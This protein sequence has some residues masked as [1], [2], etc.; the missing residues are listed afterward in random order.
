MSLRICAALG[1][2]LFLIQLGCD[3]LVPAPPLSKAARQLALG[4]QI[5]AMG[6]REAIGKIEAPVSRQSPHF[7]TLTH[8]DST[9]II[10]K[11]EESTGAD[12]L[13]TPRL[14]ARLERLSW[15][16]RAEWSGVRLR[17]TEAWDEDREHG[18]QS[19]H[20][21]GRAVDLTTSDLDPKKL[22]RLAFLAA[23]A[24]FDWVYFESRTHVHASV[25]K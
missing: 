2:G 17:V 4:D 18:P 5:P 13:M 9:E 1:L 11:D 22:G 23:E 12:R 19:A 25:R 16:V 6:E 10:F 7:R 24:G 3:G 15:L 8:N 14:R 20:Y 21:E